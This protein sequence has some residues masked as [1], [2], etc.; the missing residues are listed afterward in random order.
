MSKGQNIKT[1]KRQGQEVKSSKGQKVNLNVIRSKRSIGQKL[2]K[3]KGSEGQKV[4]KDK[5]KQNFGHV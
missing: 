2:P 1:S 4:Q 5:R 3:V